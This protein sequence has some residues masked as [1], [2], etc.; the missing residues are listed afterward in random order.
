VINTFDVPQSGAPPRRKCNRCLH[1]RPV[2]D[3]HRDRSLPGGRRYTCKQC[4]TIAARRS[5][6]AKHLATHGLA[7]VYR[8]MLRRCYS[9][10]HRSYPRYGGRGIA[11]C[12][13]W[14]SSFDA[15]FK[16]ARSHGHGRGLQLDRVDND[17]PY[18]PENCRWVTP[19]INMRNSTN[20]RLTQ[21]DVSRVRALITSGH[22][23]SEIARLFNVSP[24]VISNI[25]RGKV[26][27]DISS[28]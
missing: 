12:S 10:N 24:S 2:T 14:R 5:E 17:G 28:T 18:S 23:Q 4:A 19:A 9:P 13:E 21:Q 25:H 26:W 27:R 8:S 16:W 15:F 20:A 11:V 1:D 3:F 22:T 7:S 6:Q